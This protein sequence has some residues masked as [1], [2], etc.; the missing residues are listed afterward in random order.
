LLAIFAI[1]ILISLV[2]DLA[3]GLVDPRIR[4]PSA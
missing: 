1:F 2:I 3:Q 4:R